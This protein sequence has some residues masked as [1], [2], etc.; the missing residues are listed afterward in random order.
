M[1]AAPWQLVLGT[2]YLNRRG[3]V[4]WSATAVCSPPLSPPPHAAVG[5]WRNGTRAP[6]V[7][8]A[9]GSWQ[10]AFAT[11]NFTCGPR[12]AA[13]HGTAPPGAEASCRHDQPTLPP[14]THLLAGPVH[15]LRLVLVAA[16]QEDSVGIW[17]LERKERTAATALVVELSQSCQAASVKARGVGC[18]VGSAALVPPRSHALCWTRRHV[19]EP[20]RGPSGSTPWDRTTG[21]CRSDCLS[22]LR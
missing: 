13:P 3:D 18:C 14:H 5:G 6:S 16:A 7:F 22:M 9:G 21:R 20:P 19:H 11:N 8:A 12:A 10:R 1:V 2:W 15:M 4:T 17:R